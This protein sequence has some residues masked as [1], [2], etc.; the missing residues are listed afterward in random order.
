[1]DGDPPERAGRSR[2]R[3][4][5]RPYAHVTAP[6][7]RLVDRFATEVCLAVESPARRSP[8]VLEA[9]AELPG[10]MAEGDRRA[11]K[12]DRAAVDAAEA[13]VLSTTASGQVFPVAVVETG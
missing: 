2:P 12:L 11:K 1:V 3:R 4:G 10:L 7:R 6:L 5:G 9:L 13:L 8:W